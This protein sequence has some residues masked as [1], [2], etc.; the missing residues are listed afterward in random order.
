MHPGSIETHRPESLSVRLAWFIAENAPPFGGEP[1]Q[2]RL[3]AI[4]ARH[5][6]PETVP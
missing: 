6:V 1:L 5:A 3:N 4:D 2:T